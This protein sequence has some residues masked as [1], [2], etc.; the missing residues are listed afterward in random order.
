MLV[1]ESIAGDSLGKL[2]NFVPV[3][4]GGIEGEMSW[5]EAIASV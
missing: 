5:E 4:L 3:D 2:K 1:K